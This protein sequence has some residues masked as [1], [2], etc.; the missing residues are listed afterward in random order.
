MTAPAETGV[1]PAVEQHWAAAWN[2][3]LTAVELD[4]K[5]AE[6]LIEDLHH[7]DAEPPE[8]LQREWIAPPLLGPI[9]LEFADRARHLLQRQAE[10]SERLAEAMVFA[11]SQRRALGKLDHA[12]RPPV[13]VDRAL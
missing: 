5:F 1:G 9:P 7:S 12:E 11:R 10:V 4:V 13:F 3:A 8:P 2:A 6:Q